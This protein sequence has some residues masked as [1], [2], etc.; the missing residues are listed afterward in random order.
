MASTLGKRKRRDEL[1][2]LD[3]NPGQRVHED[4]SSELQNLF[5]QHF[6][7]AFEP[8]EDL[9]PLRANPENI[10]TAS[11]D[12]DL[13]SDWEGLSEEETERAEI[14]HY[15]N[16]HK[17]KADI[18]KEE[19]KTFMVRATGIQ[20]CQFFL[21]KMILQTTKPPTSGSKP[22]SSRAKRK[23]QDSAD[24][25]E[26]TTDAAN[27]KKDLALQ[28]LLKESHLLD[29]QSSLS[30]S[31]QNRHKALDLRLQDMGSKS[32]IFTQQKMPLAQR[33]GILA[34][35]AEREGNRRRT[36]QENGIIL[37]KAIRG[38]KKDEGKRQRGIGAPSVGKFQGGMLKLSKK[39]VAE[40]EGPKKSSRGR[41]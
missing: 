26:A 25:D 21:I 3:S 6:E 32:S 24:P 18:S 35:A 19:F 30:H 33:K 2:D 10:V 9:K 38:K 5:R 1:P 17:S 36:A 20:I 16:S 8:L 4:S 15:S 11:P 29:S 41:R 23:D 28:R 13:E 37:E 22:A 14:V 12:S 39:D 40:I 7:A 34:K 27:L 31:G